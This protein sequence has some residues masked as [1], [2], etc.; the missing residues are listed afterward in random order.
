LNVSSRPAAAYVTIDGEKVDASA[1]QDHEIPAGRHRISLVP[2]SRVHQPVSF[3]V[4]LAPGESC[5][6]VFDF[7]ARDWIV[8]E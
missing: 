4:N 3:D 7:N 2:T 8:R 5:V 1:L 6:R